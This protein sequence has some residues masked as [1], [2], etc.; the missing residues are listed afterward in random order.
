M[1]GVLAV[2]SLTACGTDPEKKFDGELLPD[3][4]VRY[5]ASSVKL[6]PGE[7]KQFVQ[8]VSAPLDHDIEI[9]DI[10]GSQGP[11][12]HHALLYA[13]PDVEA[14]GTTRAWEAADQI[15]SRFL[16]GVGG[17]GVSGG[18][19]KLPD[20]AVFRVP[21]GSGFYIQS[22]Y[23]NASDAP[24]TT[25]SA[26]EVLIQDP[27]PGATVLSMFV[28]S[29]LDIA[30][31]SGAPYEETLACDVQ[32]DTALI[33][34]VNH[35]HETGTSVTTVLHP[36]GAL[37]QTLMVKQDARW[38]KEWTTHP[39][40][41]VMTLDKPLVLHKGDR[42]ETTCKWNNNSGKTLKFPDEMCG[43][44]TMYEGPTDRACANGKWVEF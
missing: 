28:S 16:G 2:A 3:G 27:T 13:S 37:D 6:Q 41:D 8:W 36:A 42:L 10:R 29:T 33:M 11:G 40:F 24:M 30:V 25:E 9:V 26:L 14:I 20:G 12:G 22:H 23:L 31:P 38:D 4:Y 17:E 34:Y 43:F 5:E 39:N 21:A 32:D 7:T 18:L 44:I 1:V 35:I 15:S 19:S